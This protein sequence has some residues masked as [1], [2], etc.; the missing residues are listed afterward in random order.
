MANQLGVTFLAQVS[1]NGA[2]CLE[3]PGTEPQTPEND[4]GF[5]P[6]A[7]C[8]NCVTLG[9]YLNLSGP[10]LLYLQSDDNFGL[11]R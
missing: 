3:L 7:P 6:D 11:Y 2:P 10:R 1:E 5:S 8:P 4:V 9:K